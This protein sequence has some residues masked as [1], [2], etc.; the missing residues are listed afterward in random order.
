MCI[1][2]PVF[3]GQAM[4]HAAEIAMM[5]VPGL[6]VSSEV[7]VLPVLEHPVAGGHGVTIV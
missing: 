5:Q 1:T 2:H 3:A 6:G 7:P 4:E